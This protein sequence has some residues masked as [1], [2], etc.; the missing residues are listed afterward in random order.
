MRWVFNAYN[1]QWLI[2]LC[3]SGKLSDKTNGSRFLWGNFHSI[4]SAPHVTEY[5]WHLRH[6]FYPF[7]YGGWRLVGVF[8]FNKSVSIMAFDCFFAAE[9]PCNRPWLWVELAMTGLYAPQS[10]HVPTQSFSISHGTGSKIRKKIF[11]NYFPFL[12]CFCFSPVGVGLS[13]N[14]EDRCPPSISRV[15]AHRS[16]HS[17]ISFLVIHWMYDTQPF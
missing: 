16:P 4:Q 7:W 1:S 11:L 10:S 12:V 9:D 13:V 2:P 3:W 15:S 5:K 8:F 6:D 17:F 14:N